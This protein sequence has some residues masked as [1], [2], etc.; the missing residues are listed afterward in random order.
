MALLRYAAK[1]D[2]FL[3]LDCAPTPSTLAQSKERKGSNFAIW[4]P[5]PPSWMSPTLLGGGT[6]DNLFHE[7]GH[8]MHSML[9]RTKYQHVTGTRCSTDFAEVPS[10]LMEYFA[11][12]PRVLSRINRHYRTGETLPEAV[13]ESFCATKQV[14]S[15]VDVH[16]Q[17]FYSM[18]DQRY[19]GDP[20]PDSGSSTTDVLAALHAEHHPLGYPDRTAW[21]HRFSHLVGYGAR[22]YSYLMARS[23]ASSIWQEC[24]QADPLN[25][26]AGRR[27]RAVN[28]LPG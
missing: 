28:M 26:D 9:A 2:P 3:S 5:A 8:A 22:Y 19:H 21:H 24:F 23:V 25:P 15:A 20:C 12:D 4:Q 16:T 1:F 6:I 13:V 14:F 7:M 18:L 11:S 27:Y 10:T 17:L